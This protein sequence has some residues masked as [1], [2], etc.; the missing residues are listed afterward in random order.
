MMDVLTGKVAFDVLLETLSGLNKV[1]VLF[2]IAF[3]IS[4]GAIRILAEYLV[5]FITGITDFTVDMANTLIG[6]IGLQGGVDTSRATG[7]VGE[8]KDVKIVTFDEMFMVAEAE[9]IRRVV[10]GVKGILPS[11][12]SLSE[13][14]AGV[15]SIIPV[16]AG[17]ITYVTNIYKQ[18][19]DWFW[20]ARIRL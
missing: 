11:V 16:P 6:G 14:V 10:D 12:P 7:V 3:L 15:R 20:G 18:A 17:A 13:I 2:F 5:A 19:S 9:W 4:T 8:V 1:V